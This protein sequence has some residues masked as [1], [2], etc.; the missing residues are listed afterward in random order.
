[1]TESSTGSRMQVG[2]ELARIATQ[3]RK[4]RGESLEL[5]RR[6][7]SL[8]G[9]EAGQLSLAQAEAGQLSLATQTGGELSLPSA[10][11]GQLSMSPA[12]TEDTG[13]VGLETRTASHPDRPGFS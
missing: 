3:P 9:G 5:F 10:E 13:P 4:A 11:P 1:M 6:Q 2:E 12:K 8:S 7:L